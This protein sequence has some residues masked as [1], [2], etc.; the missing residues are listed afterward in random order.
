MVKQKQDQ[1]PFDG[2]ER[3]EP[4]PI[5][6]YTSGLGLPP[7]SE[8]LPLLLALMAVDVACGAQKSATRSQI[9]SPRLPLECAGLVAALWRGRGHNPSHPKG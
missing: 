6:R 4:R 3:C 7:P 1:S 8:H 2:L 9:K 5:A